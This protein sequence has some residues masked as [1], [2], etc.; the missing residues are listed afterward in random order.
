S[1]KTDE[2]D[3]RGMKDL[4]TKIENLALTSLNLTLIGTVINEGGESWAII[5]DNQNNKEDKYPEGSVINGAKV[6]MI[7]RNKVVLNMDG[8]DELLV[9]G[10]EKIRAEQKKDE[11]GGGGA[12]KEE[13]TPYVI[14]KEFVGES[15]K[16][17]SQLMAQVR[18]KP[19]F[20]DSKPD[21][22]QISQIKKGSIIG[23]MGFQDGDILKSVNGQEI[24]SAEDILKL[25]NT[26][27]DSNFFS[28]GI[29][30]KNEA[31]TL[32]FKVR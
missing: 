15:I 3:K 30:R 12:R 27:K 20:K 24:R 2:S 9:M 22:F 19:H 7:L 10:I 14:S 23:N 28:M 5:K 25:Y 29:V 17:V 1:V 26:L 18:I 31:V 8:K 32:N 16:N 11:K 6:V 4:K 21:G 13:G